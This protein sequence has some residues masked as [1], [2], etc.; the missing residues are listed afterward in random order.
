MSTKR[1]DR[2]LALAIGDRIK[3]YRESMGLSQSEIG[4]FSGMTR[5]QVCSFENGKSLP[6]T[7]SLIGLSRATGM[8]VGEILGEG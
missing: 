7:I 2:V 5:A 1:F 6:G 8:T 3:S 4:E